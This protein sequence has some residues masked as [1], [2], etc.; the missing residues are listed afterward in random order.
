MLFSDKKR[1]EFGDLLRFKKRQQL[2]V[3]ETKQR[4]L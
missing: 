1:F 3:F 2:H 4:V